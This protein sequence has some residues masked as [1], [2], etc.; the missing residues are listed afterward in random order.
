MLRK[1]KFW[2]EKENHI[3]KTGPK[4]LLWFIGLWVVGF[5]TITI[6]GIIIKLFLG[7]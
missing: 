6:V 4:E 2:E 3:E 5:V 1:L 7:T